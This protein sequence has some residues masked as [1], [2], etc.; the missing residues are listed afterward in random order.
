MNE[1]KKFFLWGIGILITFMLAFST[2]N[3][4][5]LSATSK[6][7]GAIG[8]RINTINGSYVDVGIFDEYAK[9]II[10]LINA[11]EELAMALRDE[12]LNKIKRIEENIRLIK[13]DI[14][15]LGNSIGLTM[16]S[17]I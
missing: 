14:R 17:G 2:I 3:I 9:N 7:I 4:K 10:F 12:D 13:I 5:I 16:R 8:E 6:D 11:N 15:E 1:T